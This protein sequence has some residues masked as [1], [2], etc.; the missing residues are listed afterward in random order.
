MK[1][2]LTSQKGKFNEKI[3]KYF[4]YILEILAFSLIIYLIALPFYPAVK[5][6]LVNIF[7]GYNN[8]LNIEEAG[9]DFGFPESDYSV[10]RNRII[11][12]KIGVNAPIVESKS[13]EYGL[14]KGSWRVPESSTPDKGGNTV[15]TGHR[16]KYLPPNNLTFYLFHKLEINDKFSII[17]DEKIFNYRIKEIK[18][19]PA[20]QLSIMN[21]TSEPIVT[22][23]TCDPIYS[24]KNRLV[25][26]GELIV[27]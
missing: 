16:F 12:N 23:F 4:I 8:E 9:K 19:V 26:V 6:R 27:D 14:S 24:T 11:I 7:S 5:Y 22:L 15:I 2:K 10:S 13:S 25:V 18:T 17:W 20:T 3:I 21:P 1:K